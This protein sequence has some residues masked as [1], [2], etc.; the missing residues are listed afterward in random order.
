MKLKPT[1]VSHTYT[2]GDESGYK[3]DVRASYDSEWGWSGGVSFSSFGMKTPESAIQQLRTAAQQ[4]LRM[5]DE[6]EIDGQA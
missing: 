4:F 2:V 6:I 5:T 1:E 3:F